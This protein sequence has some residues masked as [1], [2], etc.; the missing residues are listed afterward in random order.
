MSDLIEQFAARHFV[1]NNISEV[2]QRRHVKVLRGFEEWLAPTPLLS[3]S[4]EQVRQWMTEQVQGGMHVNTVRFHLNMLRPF[5]RWAWEAGHLSADSWLRLKDV[6]PPRGA[7]SHSEPKP[8]TRKEITELWRAIEERWPLATPLQVDRWNRRHQLKRATPWSVM[9]R[10]GRRLQTEAIV[11]LALY[12]GLRRSEIYN[13]GIDDLHPDNAYIVVRGKRV[14]HQ[15]KVR[16]V[17]YTDAAREAV[18]RWLEYRKSLFIKTHRSV[19]LCLRKPRDREPMYETQF[20]SL[21]K[22]FGYEL[23]RLRHTCATERLRAGMPLEAV[24]RLLGHATIQQ[25]LGYAEIIARDVQKHAERSDE[26][27]MR[28]VGKPKR[29]RVAA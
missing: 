24:Q 21:L 19:W 10:H 12:C 13:L 27:F 4:P 6:K 5:W 11:S 7:T 3:E 25:T 18:T 15:E 14:D 22:L 26:E 9:G 20:N 16:K 29:A 28:A 17:P 2:R 23:H 1:L 8:Y